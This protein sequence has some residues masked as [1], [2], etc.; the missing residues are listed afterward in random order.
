VRDGKLRS[1][2]YY[3]L[4]VFTIALPPLRERTED[5]PMLVQMFVQ[6]YAE[7]NHK[8][9]VGVDNDVMEAFRAHPWPGNV[10]QL[11]NVIERALIVCEGRMIR[12][13]DLPE[14]FRSATSP[15]GGFVKI[16]LGSSLDEVEKEMISRTLEFTGG[17]KTRA[18]DVLG[19]SAKTL[20]NKL[21]RFGQQQ[22]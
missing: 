20:Y 9:V 6:H 22:R 13:N 2:L 18:A 10:R 1:D 12:K 8:D 17:N 16:R 4:N 15:D 21:E 7:Q 19:V 3:R 11:R 14:D 5:L